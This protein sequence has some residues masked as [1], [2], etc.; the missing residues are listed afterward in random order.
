MEDR[1]LR[2]LA[3]KIVTDKRRRVKRFG[4]DVLFALATAYLA[5][6]APAE[7]SAPASTRF[8]PGG[9]DPDTSEG[10]AG[11]HAAL[12]REASIIFEK[13]SDA[14][15]VGLAAVMTGEKTAIDHVGGATLQALTRK[16]LLSTD[17]DVGAVTRLGIA[18][19]A[20]MRAR[21]E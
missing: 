3:G 17:G 20:I 16:G 6:A 8:P 5:S 9:G 18:V 10:E 15:K 14:Q 11:E 19:N 13:L 1:E 12:M 2:R 4:W 21:A 7:V